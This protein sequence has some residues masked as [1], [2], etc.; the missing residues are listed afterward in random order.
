MVKETSLFYNKKGL[1]KGTSNVFVVEAGIPNKN[2]ILQ[3]LIIYHVAPGT[4][5]IYKTCIIWFGCMIFIKYRYPYSY[6]FATA[7]LSNEMF[8]FNLALNWYS[9]IILNFHK[10]I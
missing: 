8:C 6:N 7:D 9:L 4:L 3:A 2:K 1:N 5:I 10:N